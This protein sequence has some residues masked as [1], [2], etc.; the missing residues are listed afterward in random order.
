M[1]LILDT[2]YWLH[3]RFWHRDLRVTVIDVGLGSAS[4]LELPGGYTILVDGGGFSDNSSF[5][6]G[7]KIIA[8]FLWRKKIQT[9]DTLILSH[10]NS[11]HLNG[12]IYIARHFNVKKNH[13]IL[14]VDRKLDTN[15]PGFS[16]FSQIYCNTED[17][18]LMGRF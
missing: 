7:E 15:R 4:L 14:R 2:G 9:V 5:N 3:Q 12:L 18:S 13:P 16:F 8:P 17:Y 1:I 6:V 11:D 10:P